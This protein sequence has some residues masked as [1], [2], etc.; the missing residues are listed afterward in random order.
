MPKLQSP[1]TQQS[2]YEQIAQELRRQIEAGTLRP[3]DRMP[4]LRALRER[5][6]VAQETVDKAHNLLEKEGL[7]VRSQRSGIFVAHPEPKAATGLIGISGMSFTQ[8]DFSA[9]WTRLMEGVESAA[10]E[11]DAQ[12]LLLNADSATGWD[13]VDG[14]LVNSMSALPAKYVP[15]DLPLV[16]FF[17][18]P[19]IEGTAAERRRVTANSDVVL[20]D[21]Y[22]GMHA[23]TEHL[24]TLGHR[25]IAYLNNSKGS[26]AFYIP[27]LNGYRDALRE[28]GVTPDDRWLRS[29]TGPLSPLYFMNSSR[30][31]MR[32]WLQED[33]ASLG[34]TALLTHNDDVAWGAVDAMMEAGIDVPGQ[35]SVVGYDGTEIADCCDPKLTTV[36]VP[37]RAMGRVGVELLWKRINGEAHEAELVL[38]TQLRVQDSTAPV[39]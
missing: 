31:T 20:I 33:W 35:V 19:A 18:A 15:R 17:W 8:T 13:K 36:D 23:A 37:L 24:L 5:H 11:Y 21:D 29:L 1:E 34:C 32:R 14:L 12:I 3:G 9:Y 2:R 7:I 28:A 38:P 30:Q 16:S 4:S 39:A 10:R 6:G 22:V 27:R 26:G 25:R